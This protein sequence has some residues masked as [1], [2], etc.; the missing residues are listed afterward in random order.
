MTADPVRVALNG[1][2]AE[3]AAILATLIRVTGEWELA[4][5]CVQDA[6]E[7]ALTRWPVE[8]VPASPAGMADDGRAQPRDRSAPEADD[9]A[10]QAAGGGADGRAQGAPR[11]TCCG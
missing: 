6:V 10:G 5:D 8:G 4:E 3:R 9:R 11:T 1:V 7:R 2:A